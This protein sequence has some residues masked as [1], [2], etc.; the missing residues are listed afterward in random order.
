MSKGTARPTRSALAGAA[1]LTTAAITLA[2]WSPPAH[3]APTGVVVTPLTAGDGD[4]VEVSGT[5]CTG[6]VDVTLSVPDAAG[7]GTEVADQ[8][9]VAPA[10]D[11]S[12]TATPTMQ[13]S[14]AAVVASCDGVE[15]EPVVIGDGGSPTD[16]AAGVVRAAGAIDVEVD[17][18][19]PGTPV[20]V[21]TL[22]GEVVAAAPATP[23][24]RT[25]FS[26]PGP[27][28]VVLVV[29][30]LLD[31][32][33]VSE[34]VETPSGATLAVAPRVTTSGSAVRVSGDGCAG[35][36]AGRVYVSVRG[37]SQDW[38]ELGTSYVGTWIDTAADGTWE[39]PFTMPREVVEV[40]VWCSLEEDL[41]HQVPPLTVV[42]AADGPAEILDAVRDGEDVVVQA[43]S[44]FE[45]FTL[46]GR[47]LATESG[48][49]EG[50]LRVLDAPDRFLLLDYS[51]FGE[52]ADPE[53]VNFGSPEQ[54]LVDVTPAPAPTPPAAAPVR[55]GSGAELA[56]TGSTAVDATS[57]AL[58]LVVAGAACVRAGR[59]RRTRPVR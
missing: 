53:A 26:V 8:E 20:R 23:G 48:A 56:D 38:Y 46:D 47:A 12:W 49:W 11:G 51:S 6:A 30:G 16:V 54:R 55:T 17:G 4:A 52:N 9:T 44:S 40:N 43:R 41:S 3:A 15:S 35:V 22:Q 36:G 5:G 57:L 18:L 42:G 32:V 33:P 28:N 45:P 29:L 2:P 21:V 59:R 31:G 19:D 27:D 1:L 39:L 10:G 25:S 14:A 50:P 34:L 7:T 58:V 37:G 24:G 13:G